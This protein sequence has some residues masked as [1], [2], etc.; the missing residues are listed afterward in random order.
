M[1]MHSYL[2]QLIMI[3]IEIWMI[4]D[5]PFIYPSLWDARPIHPM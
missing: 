4:Y 2:V 1:M 3:F 5:D